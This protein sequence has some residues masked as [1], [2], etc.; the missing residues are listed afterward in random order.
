MSQHYTNSTIPPT[1]E[2]NKVAM[3]LS[4]HNLSFYKKEAPT[5]KHTHTQT[6]KLFR[7]TSHPYHNL[8]I[9]IPIQL[10]EDANKIHRREYV[11]C[12]PKRFRDV[13]GRMPLAR[14]I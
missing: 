7:H 12:P 14:D 2:K 4:N 11:H 6:V 10:A 9:K 3:T 13:V 1:H 5:H 8:W